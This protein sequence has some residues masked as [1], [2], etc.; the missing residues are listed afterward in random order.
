MK[1]K[2]L[3][4]PVFAAKGRVTTEGNPANE[5]HRGKD[6]I[7]MKYVKCTKQKEIEQQENTCPSFFPFLLSKSIRKRMQGNKKKRVKQRGVTSD[8][9]FNDFLE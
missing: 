9:L 1:H 8:L 4:P 2:N 7:G 3:P 6:P 5:E